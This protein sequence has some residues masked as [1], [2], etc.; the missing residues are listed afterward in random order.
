MSIIDCV[1][2]NGFILSS[3][4]AGKNRFNTLIRLLSCRWHDKI[5]L[6][7]GEGT[8][9]RGDDASL[10]CLYDFC[11]TGHTISGPKK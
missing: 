9:L 1:V 3:R 11:K 8:P 4:E 7:P 10:I 6:P 5:H 2:G